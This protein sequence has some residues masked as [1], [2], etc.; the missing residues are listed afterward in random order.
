[1]GRNFSQKIMDYIPFLVLFYDNIKLALCGE[2]SCNLSEN[3]MI[4][5]LSFPGYKITEEIYDNNQLKI[6]RGHSVQDRT[7]VLIKVLQAGASPVEVARLM[8][9]Y[10]ITLSLTIKGIIKPLRLERLG[11][12][13]ALIMEDNGNIS[14]G[15]Y[16]LTSRLELSAFFFIALQL[17]ETLGELHQLGIIHRDLRPENILIHPSTKQVYIIDFGSAVHLSRKGQ[18]N[19]IPNPFVGTLAYMSPEQIGRMNMTVDQ[20][21]DYYSLGVILYEILTE[22]LPLQ[23]GNHIQWVN[24]HLAQR[25]KYPREIN[26]DIPPAVSAIIM[27]LLAKTPGERYQ[28]ALGLLADLKE[29]Q[30]QWSRAGV[31]DPFVLAHFDLSD[32]FRLPRKLYGR[33]KEVEALTAAFKR[34]SSGQTELLVVH[35]YAGIGKTVLIQETLKPLVAEKGY[36]ITGKFDQLQQNIPYAP[37]IQA[38]EDLI[39]QF[40]TESQASLTTW[41]GK[42]LQALGRS[43]AVITEVIPAVELIVGPQPPVESLQ[44]RE[45]QNRFRMVFRKFIQVLAQKEHPLI[46]FLDDLQWADQASLN[47]FQ[48]IS[49][50]LNNR[51]LFLI[52]AYRDNE[53]TG[54]NLLLSTLEELKREDIPV[55]QMALGSLDL[56]HTSQ[57]IADTLHCAKERSESLAEILFRKTGGNPFFLSQLLQSAYEENL[58]SFNAGDGCFEWFPAVIHELPMADDVVKLMLGKLQKLPLESRNVLKLASCLGN[59]FNLKI[60]AIVCEKSLEHT[61]ADL[62]QSIVEGLVLPV[63]DTRYEFLHDRV[64]QAAYSLVSE[65]EKNET[66]VKIGRLIL[67]NTSQDELDEKIFDVMDHLNRGLDLV[68]D[69]TERFKLAEYNLLAGKKAKS[70]TAYGS[71]LNYFISGLDLLPDQAWDEH[72]QVCYDLHLERSD[73]EYLCSHFDQAE[74]LFDLLLSKAKT[75]LE[76]ADIYGIKMAFH[77]S[78]ERYQAS[79]RLGIKGLSLLG[80]SLPKNPGKIEFFK[81]IFGL[82][83]VYS[84]ESWAI[85]LIYRK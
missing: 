75:D 4:K 77:L 24:A 85:Q 29:C 46:I 45:A 11:L 15:K 18:N 54:A 32:R 72:Y 83:G 82:N 49:E 21:S 33:E 16:L 52:G 1:M 26:P 34:V 51:Y 31:I 84:A 58:L 48:S 55:W 40:L 14:L 78:Q 56:T 20:R 81:E 38:F 47:L 6:Y 19:L 76:R 66:H 25:P 28:S 5:M 13:I 61:T 74:Q 68:K 41:K 60:L 67:Q 69:P 2:L 36:F 70:T 57:F 80:V 71:A 39:Q 30:R 17:T 3:G 43:G 62:W 10:E 9:E 35:G 8:N 73:C 12:N 79:L 27:K 23:A 37:I 59:S 65:E 22:Q 50:D 7:P 64:Q 44:P 42:L 53:V 63:N